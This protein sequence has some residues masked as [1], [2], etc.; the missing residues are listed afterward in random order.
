MWHFTPFFDIL[1]HFMVF[2]YNLL[3]CSVCNILLRI[4]AFHRTLPSGLFAV[5]CSIFQ[6]WHFTGP[7]SLVSSG[8]DEW[9]CHRQ[10]QSLT[11]WHIGSSS[12]MSVFIL[13]IRRRCLLPSASV[14]IKVWPTSCFTCTEVLRLICFKPWRHFSLSFSQESAPL[15]GLVL[16][17][18]VRTKVSWFPPSLDG[19]QVYWL[20]MN[21]VRTRTRKMFWFSF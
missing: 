14:F 7:S 5:F 11:V 15:V 8:F 21:A 9:C 3:F 16:I 19:N 20:Q 12:M 18:S 10:K 6:W 1:Q 2:C 4:V 13:W 17:G